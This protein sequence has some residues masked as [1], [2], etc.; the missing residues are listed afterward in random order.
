M[1][2][3]K[4][5][6]LTKTNKSTKNNLFNVRYVS[7]EDK[8][9]VS[10]E[11]HLISQRDSVQNN[12]NNLWDNLSLS[13]DSNKNNIVTINL[14]TNNPPNDLNINV[15]K[16]FSSE[17]ENLSRSLKKTDSVSTLNSQISEESLRS[18][19]NKNKGFNLSK[20]EEERALKDITH[21]FIKESPLCSPLTNNQNR[22]EV[23]SVKE[24]NAFSNNSVKENK[25]RTSIVAPAKYKKSKLN[26]SG[27]NKKNVCRFI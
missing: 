12:A 6:S 21:L 14:N 3:K 5:F 13:S 9:N 16:G 2:N 15:I 1:E 19:N 11:F 22:F 27:R 17:I 25:Y 23:F 24:I 4:N 7:N 8:E 10:S 18:I 26:F 20:E